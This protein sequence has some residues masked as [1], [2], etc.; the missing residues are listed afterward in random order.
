MMIICATEDLHES[1]RNMALEDLTYKHLNKRARTLTTGVPLV[2]LLGH[3]RFKT[4][5]CPNESEVGTISSTDR[6]VAL[7]LEHRGT[8]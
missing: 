7:F 6:L 1:Y 8:E 3:R 2:V 4:L 5:R